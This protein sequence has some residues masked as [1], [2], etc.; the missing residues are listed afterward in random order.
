MIWKE[1]DVLNDTASSCSTRNRSLSFLIAAII[2]AVPLCFA[3]KGYLSLDE[4]CSKTY[5]Q[6][7]RER[8]RSS[9]HWLVL[10]VAATV[11]L[12]SSGLWV[13][14][15]IIGPFGHQVWPAILMPDPTDALFSTVQPHL[16][17]L[18][19]YVLYFKAV[20]GAV[21]V[22]SKLDVGDLALSFVGPPCTLYLWLSLGDEWGAPLY[23]LTA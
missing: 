16:L 22:N 4:T 2:H 7:G 19:M 10:V 14:C 15:T 12:M 11:A 8:I 21:G 9:F 1:V 18:F 5:H 6:L 13:S 20:I 23:L 17:R 3:I